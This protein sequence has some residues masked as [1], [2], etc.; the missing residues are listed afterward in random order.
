M[1]SSD[2]RP[3]RLVGMRGGVAAGAVLVPVCGTA[4]PSAAA[5]ID[6][7]S[8]AIGV[9]AS[10]A[11]ESLEAV[12]T[13]EGIVV[14]HK[15]LLDEDEFGRSV[16][17]HPMLDP[18]N[19]D[20]IVRVDIP[21]DPS[22]GVGFKQDGADEIVIGLP[23]AH[24]ADEADYGD[25]GLATYDNNDGSTTVPIPQPDGTLQ[26]TTVIDGPGAPNR[27]AYPITLP[28]GGE[29]VDAGNGYFAILNSEG[30]PAAMIEPAWALDADGEAVTTNYEVVGN[31]LVQVVDHGDGDAY[32]IVA[33]PA[34]KGA[35]ISKVNV[36]TVTQG[37]TVAVY[38]VNGWA[39][40]AFNNYWAEYKL[41]VSSTYEGTK[42]KN[43][44]QCHWDFA[45]FKT[46]WNLDSWRPNVSYW[47]TI[48]A[49]CN[50]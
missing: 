10:I 13:D 39:I 12:S 8:G 16:V 1:V 32:P 41:Y 46:P 6:D 20:S 33:D 11:P 49:G 30:L 36:N 3:K 35:Y 22:E 25:F 43:Q 37:K 38:P 21:V 24:R 4:A 18:T 50:P 29:L 2:S 45:P 28:N 15:E 9:I 19:P 42:Y 27:Y 17:T 40:T 26:I 31:A 47:D 14:A 34:V 44:L 23:N 48:V 5:E 7:S